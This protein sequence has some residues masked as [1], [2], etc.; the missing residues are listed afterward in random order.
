MPLKHG[1]ESGQGV[2]ERLTQI[3]R[4]VKA[5]SESVSRSEK[6]PKPVATSMA[7]ALDEAKSSLSLVGVKHVDRSGNDTR[8]VHPKLARALGELVKFGWSTQAEE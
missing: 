4:D 8:R 1:E 6:L 5:L 3:T 7:T 2:D